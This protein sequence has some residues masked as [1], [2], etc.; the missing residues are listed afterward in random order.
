MTLA[1]GDQRCLVVRSA[2]R[3]RIVRVLGELERPLDVLARSLVVPLVAP[4]ARAPGED[5]RAKLVGRQTRALGEGERLVEEADGRLDAVQLLAA[6]SEREEHLGP[7]DVREPATLGDRTR[8]VE[9]LERGPEG[10]QAHLRPAGADESP[11]LELEQSRRAG[12]LN[13]GLVL[14]GRLIV[15][16]GLDQRLR[17]GERAFEPAALVGREAVGEE[18]GVDAQPRREP[19]DRLAGRAGLPALDLRDVL[20]GEPVARELALGQ[21][22]ADTQLAQALSQAQPVGC[23]GA[24]RTKGGV[25]CGHGGWT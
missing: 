17:T 21:A 2:D 24:I 10:A 22:G 7:L 15:A 23:G 13:E 18:A 12:C 20:L 3:A 4:A 11:N 9:E 19:V 16:V 1:V 25:S 5:V 8:L 14:V 6:D